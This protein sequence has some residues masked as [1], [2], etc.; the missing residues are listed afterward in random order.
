MSL[1][2]VVIH[3]SPRSARILRNQE[4]E[5]TLQKEGESSFYLEN[6]VGG[7]RWKL[8]A[9][10]AGIV[11]PFS[12][13]CYEM[14]SDGM[15]KEG[16]DAPSESLSL[17]VKDNI[18]L[19]NQNFYSIGEA[20][21]VDGLQEGHFIGSKPICRLLNFPFSD[22]DQIDEETKHQMRRH[23][24]IAVGNIHGLG[25]DGYHL[26]LYGEELSDIALPLVA[27]TYLLYTTR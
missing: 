24:G 17:R 11:R 6:K 12:I 10:V 26:E 22:L 5:A 4:D 25:A 27:C 14:Q 1:D 21:P 3:S 15:K 18:F 23:R 19:H 8:I 20:L 13:S 16:D 2:Y 9:K 7:Q